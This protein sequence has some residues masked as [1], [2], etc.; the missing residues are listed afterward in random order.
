MADE[1]H[2]LSIG[3]RVQCPQCDW[4]SD[5]GGITEQALLDAALDEHVRAEH[6]QKMAVEIYGG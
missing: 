2:E 3:M 6:N 1:T 5:R 4:V